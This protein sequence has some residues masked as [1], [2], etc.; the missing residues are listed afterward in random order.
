MLKRILMI[1]VLAVVSL[2]FWLVAKPW[3]TNPTWFTVDYHTWL[4][5]LIGLVV[6]GAIAGT[7]MTLLDRRLLQYSASAVIGFLFLLVF[8]VTKLNLLAAAIM[9]VFH[10]YAFR[11]MHGALYNHL[12]IN[13]RVAVNSGLTY[14]I[15]PLLIM[16]SFV[17]YANP[18]VQ[19]S[20]KHNT[21]PP[22][23]TQAVEAASRVV[24]QTQLSKL[25][26]SQRS[27]AQRELTNQVTDLI[28]T[29]ARPY[30]EYFPP[31]LAFGLFL[32][33]QGLGFV[34]LPIAGLLAWGLYEVLKAARFIRITEKDVKAEIL[35]L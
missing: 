25:S 27:I 15:M 30:R 33:L 13:F 1:V 21:L 5:P 20:S 12:K 18:D 6:I 28:N 8:G 29:E 10:A 31:L 11:T 19:A 22:I 17:Y 35:E 9:L 23:I 4:L 2:G 16:L 26:P 32:V 34:F 7:V 3:I 14:V 24:A